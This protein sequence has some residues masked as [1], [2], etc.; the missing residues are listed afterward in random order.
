MP[1]ELSQAITSEQWEHAQILVESKKAQA[2]QFS[3]RAGFFDGIKHAL[4]LPIHEACANPNAPFKLIQSL[5]AAYPEG[6]Q[7]RESAYQR[8]P[9]HIAC[10]KNANKDV[11]NH[12]IECYEYGCLVPDTL[13]RLPL[14]YALSNGADDSITDLLVGKNPNA[15]RGFDRRGWLPLHVACSVGASTHVIKC[16]LAA[17]PDASITLTYKGTS[18][19]RCMES[20]QAGNKEEVLNLLESYRIEA[21]KRL[22]RPASRP[23]LGRNVV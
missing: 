1:S 6:I 12:L 5:V 23:S 8:L 19:K 20:H 17:Y 16:I 13:G 10:R 22:G 9:L 21:E 14:H 3:G 7:I 15:A 2:K 18:V 4:V 11:V